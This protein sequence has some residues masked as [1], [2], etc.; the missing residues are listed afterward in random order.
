MWMLS[1]RICTELK[2][3]I[4]AKDRGDNSS[5]K[6]GKASKGQILQTLP[7]VH[8]LPFLSSSSFQHHKPLSSW[9]LFVFLL[10]LTQCLFLPSR[11]F[12]PI[13][14]LSLSSCTASDLPFLPLALF[15]PCPHTTYLYSSFSFSSLPPVPTSDSH[16]FL[17]FLSF[18]FSHFSSISSSHPFSFFLVHTSYLCSSP[19]SSTSS[20]LHPVLTS[21]IHF[22]TFLLF[23][24]FFTLLPFLSL[25][26]SITSLICPSSSR[27]LIPPP[28]P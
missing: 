4:I 6:T 25:T 18:S 8:F 28:L 21:D 12:F 22:S 20:S 27:Q 24:L 10:F 14:F 7:P 13:S 16:C 23:L 26:L 1:E 15:L 2:T 9:S 5:M 11:P 17:P 3:V 19:S